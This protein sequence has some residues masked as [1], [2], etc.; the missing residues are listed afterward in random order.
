MPNNDRYYDEKID[1]LHQIL[2]G[3]IDEMRVGL[4]AKLDSQQEAIK[5]LT[6]VLMNGVSHRT[7]ENH[8]AIQEMRKHLATREELKEAVGERKNADQAYVELRRWKVRTAI[9]GLGLSATI[10]GLIVRMFFLGGSG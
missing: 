9:A 8:E 1:S 10:V 7:K 3:K 5:E 6:K 4:S 2:D